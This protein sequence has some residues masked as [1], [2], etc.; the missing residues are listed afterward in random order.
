LF[1]HP[2]RDYYVRELIATVGAGAGATQ[3]ELAFLCGCEIVLRS[4][5]GNQVLYRVN[6]KHPL[7][8]E[9]SGIVRKTWGA[10]VVLRN[11]LAKIAPVVTYA[12][13]FGS[14]A[15]GEER[16]GSDL[17]L[18]VIGKAE[19]GEVVEVLSSAQRSL[20]R[21]V[22]PVVYDQGEFLRK[23]KAGNHFLRTVAKAPLIFLVGEKREFAR[24]VR[25]RL[26]RTA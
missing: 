12:A 20:G 8:P 3:R 19:F 25:S 10:E 7:Y 18:L 15:R 21:E 23:L 16:P 9:L 6:P 1:G 13:I 5:R 14:Y 24:M 22:N 26:D 17:D 2:E 4:R 11:A